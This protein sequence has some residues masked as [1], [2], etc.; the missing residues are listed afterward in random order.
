MLNRIAVSGGTYDDWIDAQYMHDR[1]TRISTPI[2]HGGLSKELVF[3]EVVSNAEA[4]STEGGQPLGTLAGKGVMSKKHKGGRVKI[5]VNNPGYIMGI[6][7]LTPRI[8]YSQGNKW[9][10][11]LKMNDLHVPSLDEIGFQELITEQMA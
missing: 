4:S 2:Y 8:D 5:R 1:L 11:M 9:D 10:T 7:S 3:Q 6:V